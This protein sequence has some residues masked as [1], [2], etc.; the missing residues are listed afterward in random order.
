VNARSIFRVS[1]LACL[2]LAACQASPSSGAI[3]TQPA[4]LEQATPTE[5]LQLLRLPG[6]DEPPPE[7][8]DAAPL[9]RYE[10]VAG[11]ASR[12]LPPALFAALSGDTAVVWLPDHRLARFGLDGAPRLIARSVSSPPWVGEDRVVFAPEVGDTVELRLLRQGVETTLARG[13]A[14]AGMFRLGPDARGVFF[15]GAQNG[16]VAGL[17]FARVDRD[18]ARCLTNCELRTGSP[19]GDAFVPPPGSAESLEFDG[20]SVRYLDMNGDAVTRS[21]R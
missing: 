20:D 14:S 7:A 21:F 16:G 12:Q 2:L 13:L 1:T 11:L 10:L 5:E 8:S 15:V 4:A 9:L 17:W 3:A 6:S 19:W 18:E